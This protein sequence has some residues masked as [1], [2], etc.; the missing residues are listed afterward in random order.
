[1][2]IPADSGIRENL[3]KRTEKT[4]GLM[5]SV[6][7]RVLSEDGSVTFK[8]LPILSETKHWFIVEPLTINMTKEE[9]EK[10]SY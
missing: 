4:D 2:G 3:K 9:I 10:V 1:M 7:S 5:P 6:F 8:I